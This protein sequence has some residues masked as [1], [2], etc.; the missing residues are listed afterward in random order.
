MPTFLY[1]T[2][3]YINVIGYP[4]VNLSRSA[5]LVAYHPLPVAAHRLYTAHIILF[6]LYFS[7]FSIF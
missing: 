5:A 7:I 6:N 1:Q 4:A 3:L 2:I